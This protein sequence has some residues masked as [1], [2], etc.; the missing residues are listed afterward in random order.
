MTKAKTTPMAN[1]TKHWTEIHNSHLLLDSSLMQQTFNRSINSKPIFTQEQGIEYY[2]IRWQDCHI[3]PTIS[4]SGFH[5]SFIKGSINIQLTSVWLV[6]I[7]PTKQV[8]VNF[9][10]AKLL[11]PKPLKMQV[12]LIGIV[13]LTKQVSFL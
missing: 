4:C 12:S 2:T 9:T 3:S 5:F 13:A 7:E 1:V 8:S 11:N 10:I 6:W